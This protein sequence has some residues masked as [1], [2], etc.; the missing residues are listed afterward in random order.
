MFAFITSSLLLP[1]Q[2]WL[3]GYIAGS[4][5]LVVFLINIGV[6]IKMTLNKVLLSMKKKKAKKAAEAAAKSKVTTLMDDT[7]GVDMD[8]DGG[9]YSWKNDENKKQ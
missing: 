6:M 1:D 2:Q 8:N 7:E 9:F 3:A 5:L 4:I